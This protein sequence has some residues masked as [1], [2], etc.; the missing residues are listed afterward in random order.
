MADQTAAP[1][2]SAVVYTRDGGVYTGEQA[3]PG[4]GWIVPGSLADKV[5]GYLFGYDGGASIA[6]PASN[7]NDVPAS[8]T[9]NQNYSW[10]GGWGTK[11]D[12]QVNDPR[13]SWFERML[14]SL[15][16][17]VGGG[18]GNAVGGAIKPPLDAA[19]GALLP[20]LVII[21]A[22]AVVILFALGKFVTVQARVTR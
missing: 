21:L 18:I 14:S 20:I 12:T 11:T 10:S 3:A 15:G 13:P 16:R 4:G 17:A 5:M 6:N 9:S 1:D 2:G 22:G 7:G 19:S 8:D